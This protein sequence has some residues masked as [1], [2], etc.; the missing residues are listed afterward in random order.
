MYFYFINGYLINND[1]KSRGKKGNV[2][3]IFENFL[4]KV[5]KQN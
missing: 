3:F 2:K 1:E 4:S 5:V